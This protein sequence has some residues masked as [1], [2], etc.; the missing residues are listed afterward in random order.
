MINGVDVSHWQQNINWFLL[1][2]TKIEFV[3]I[4]ATEGLDLI[5]PNFSINWL[6]ANNARLIRGAY[7][8]FH[9]SK[10]PVAQAEMFAKVVGP[11]N[12]EDLPC[13]MDWE[14][15]DGI[16]TRTDM[17][18]AYQ[19]LQTIERLT[20]KV[21]II[22]SNYYF[23]QM[24]SPANMSRGANIKS[25]SFER[26]PTWLAHYG[27]KTPF[28][29]SGFQNWTFWQNGNDLKLP[30]INGSVCDSNIF[31]GSLSQLKDFALKSNV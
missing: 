31:N 17:Y 14:T 7:H 27:V 6:G 1:K 19:F 10:D 29:C 30:G 28:M 2:T 25:N 12:K 11:L 22:Y 20:K 24:T 16:P 21:P 26:Y 8:F 5:D 18:A 23:L 15:S 4:K 3:F 13:V 9:P